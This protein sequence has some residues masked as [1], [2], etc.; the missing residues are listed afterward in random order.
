M[1]HRK[2]LFGNHRIFLE[3][4]D[5]HMIKIYESE[6]TMFTGSRLYLDLNDEIRNWS[7]K[8]FKN[9]SLVL[10]IDKEY[11]GKHLKKYHAHNINMLD[12]LYVFFINYN[13]SNNDMPYLEFDYHHEAFT[14][15]TKWS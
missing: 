13:K 8:V 14:F 12:P 11:V 1:F 6:Q 9:K 15:L 7:E 2:G 4:D 3:Q 5:Y 10:H